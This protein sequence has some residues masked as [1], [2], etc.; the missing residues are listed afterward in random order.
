MGYF[1]LRNKFKKK[2][3]R[4]RTSFPYRLG[5]ELT[6]RKKLW[7]SPSSPSEALAYTIGIAYS[8]PYR[9]HNFLQREPQISPRMAFL[10]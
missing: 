6:I 4:Q 1:C 2:V 5:F 10:K 7:S 3:H 8:N 9:E